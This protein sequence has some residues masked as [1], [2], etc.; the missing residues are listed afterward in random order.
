MNEDDRVITL[1]H[2]TVAGKADDVFNNI[3][4]DGLSRTYSKA[5]AQEPGVFFTQKK[6][7]AEGHARGLSSLY[8][9]GDPVL[10]ELEVKISDLSKGWDFDYEF[11]FPDVWRFL[12]N[13]QNEID[14]SLPFADSVVIRDDGRRA[15]ARVPKGYFED[16]EAKKYEW[17]NAA[18][19]IE[20]CFSIS[21]VEITD[22]SIH[23]LAHDRFEDE[24]RVFVCHKN[25]AMN[26]DHRIR[27]AGEYLCL[28]LRDK[29]PE[30][31]NKAF[32]HTISELAQNENLWGIKYVGARPLPVAR[33][34]KL[35]P[36]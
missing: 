27:A 30:E 28:K 14:R 19:G 20:E 26:H 17:F 23:L 10:V 2:G 18:A 25:S 3:A 4:K 7:F 8:G 24:R 5:P 36:D 34:T 6:V 33:M 31:Y 16:P 13:F 29:Y 22:T 35:E 21:G 32:E 15:L 9:Q 11:L 12:K 1:W